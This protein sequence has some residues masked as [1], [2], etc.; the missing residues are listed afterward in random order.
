MM[1]SPHA[2]RISANHDADPEDEAM[3]LADRVLIV[4]DVSLI[5][6]CLLRH[7]D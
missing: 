2:K 3:L 7:A 6:L 1:M 4:R 5:G